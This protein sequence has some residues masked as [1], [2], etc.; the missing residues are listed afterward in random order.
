MDEASGGGARLV[1]PGDSD[2]LAAAIDETL[3][4]GIPDEQRQ[5]GFDAVSRHTWEAS[6]AKHVEAYRLA[7][8][9]R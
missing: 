7:S 9:A 8:A 6:A 3:E 4:H 2:E 5:L 1:T